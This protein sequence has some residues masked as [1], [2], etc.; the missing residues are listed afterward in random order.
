MLTNGQD[1]HCD[2]RETSNTIR[3]PPIAKR[4]FN[5]HSSMRPQHFRAAQYGSGPRN[6]QFD[7]DCGVPKVWTHAAVCVHA[8]E[9]LACARVSLRLSSRPSPCTQGSALTSPSPPRVADP[10]LLAHAWGHQKIISNEFST[11]APLWQY[12]GFICEH[13]AM[14]P[15]FWFSQRGGVSLQPC[16]HHSRQQMLARAALTQQKP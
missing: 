10:G 7:V 15:P 6:A 8:L 1:N 12:V 11:E 5:K 16:C 3:Y 4:E 9:G 2:G 13:T 14:H